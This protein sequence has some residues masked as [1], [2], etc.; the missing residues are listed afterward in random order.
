MRCPTCKNSF[1]PQPDGLGTY[2]TDEDDENSRE[3]VEFSIQ[4]CPSCAELIVVRQAGTGSN[5]TPAGLVLEDV[6]AES[7]I[8]P[9]KDE[10]VVA[11]EVP[12]DYRAEYLEAHDALKYSAKASAALSRRLLQKTLRE[13]LNIKKRDLSLEIDA[14]IDSGTVMTQR[15]LHRLGR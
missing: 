6:E 3:A 15:F 4:R 12:D 14:F 1:H 13:K 5:T 2:W 8:Y 9:V 10:F 7:V 11:T